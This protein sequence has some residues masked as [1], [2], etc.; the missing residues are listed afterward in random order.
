MLLLSFLAEDLLLRIV[1]IEEPI[2]RAVVLVDVVELGPGLHTASVFQCEIDSGVGVEGCVLRFKLLLHDHDKLRYSHG[3]GNEKLLAGDLRHIRSPVTRYFA[4]NGDFIGVLLE[5]FFAVGCP[6][7]QGD[8]FFKL[9]LGE[10][11]PYPHLGTLGDL[12]NAL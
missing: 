12:A 3:L 1:H 4:N 7:G 10:V 9:E 6:L 2:V 5:D 8:L 11:A